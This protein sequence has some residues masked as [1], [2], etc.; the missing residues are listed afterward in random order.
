M[1]LGKQA[2]V[3]TDA[4]IKTCLTHM[5]TM[6]APQ[7]NTAMFLLSVDAVLRAKEIA[8]VTWAMV[9][10]AQGNLTDTIRLQNKASKCASGGD[11]GMSK[12]LFEALSDLQKSQNATQGPIIASEL[13]RVAMSPNPVVC[14][15]SG[16]YEAL[17]FE[18]FSSHSVRRTIIT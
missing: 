11:V 15:F 1:A 16:L 8:S 13:T 6:R 14:W 9:T 18:G 5:Q 7:R 3:L 12:L 4:Q 2:K 10:G 17:G